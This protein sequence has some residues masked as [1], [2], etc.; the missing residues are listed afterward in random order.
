MNYVQFIEDVRRVK[1]DHVRLDTPEYTEIV[2]PKNSLED[3]EKVMGRFF[4]PAS[5]P[6]G[7]KP[8][9]EHLALTDKY[10]G[11][12]PDQ[13]LYVRAGR[14]DGAM[15][16]FWPWGNGLLITVKIYHGNFSLGPEK[17][18]GILGRIFKRISDA[19]E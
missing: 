14:E 8:T 2:I 10:G 1:H 12:R 16:M 11:I 9:P 6:L 3:M 5:K 4:G 7:L 15:A 18:Q 19:Q 17:T 13:I